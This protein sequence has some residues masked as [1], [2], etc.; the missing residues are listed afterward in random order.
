MLPSAKKK[1]FPDA[2]QPSIVPQPEHAAAAL[3][4]GNPDACSNSVAASRPGEREEGCIGCLEV[5]FFLS[6]G[7]FHFRNCA[8]LCLFPEL[9]KET[10]PADN[11]PQMLSAAAAGRR[12]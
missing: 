10:D 8:Y 6:S 11:S 3:R 4:R 5:S 12:C 1:N 9:L 2:F 7:S